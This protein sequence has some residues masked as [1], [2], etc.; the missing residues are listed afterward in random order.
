MD[1]KPTKGFSVS[2][3][4]KHHN[5][6]K[7]MLL[8]CDKMAE[9]Y[10][11]LDLEND[12]FKHEWNS[13]SE[14]YPNMDIVGAIDT[15]PIVVSKGNSKN[16]QPKYKNAVLKA[17]NCCTLT[18]FIFGVLDEKKTVKLWHGS[19][20]DSTILKEQST[21]FRTHDHA[22]R[23]DDGEVR[24]LWLVDGAFGQY[25]GV[26]R[27]YGAPTLLSIRNSQG[28]EPFI[29]ALEF[30]ELL[31]FIRARIEHRFGSGSG[32]CKWN[33][34]RHFTGNA[35]EGG[36][37]D[38]VQAMYTVAM[39]A[40]NVEGYVKHG[41]KGFYPLSL[42]DRKEEILK[43]V[44]EKRAQLQRYKRSKLLKQFLM[45][46]GLLH[47]AER[48]DEE[49]ASNA[50]QQEE[51]ADELML[52]IAVH[53]EQVAAEEGQDPEAHE[54]PERFPEVAFPPDEVADPPDAVAFPVPPQRG[55][56]IGAADFSWEIREWLRAC[57]WPRVELKLEEW[58]L[59][60]GMVKTHLLF[61]KSGT[62]GE[63]TIV[64]TALKAADEVTAQFKKQVLEKE[65]ARF[66]DGIRSKAGVVS[67]LHVTLK[68]RLDSWLQN[69]D[70][71]RLIARE[72][73]H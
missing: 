67:W 29:K 4:H 18:G 38:K 30:N 33:A 11:S 2:N 55:N 61:A 41:W 44:Q 36:S 3:F 64:K 16:M 48:A 50:S 49:E 32:L 40:H 34:V 71:V 10:V 8:I 1:G 21:K 5:L 70:N 39:I 20:A 12:A 17:L 15:V 47:V 52:Q 24:T 42:N 51:A 72:S 73:T 43:H 60:Q 35:P 62:A 26:L 31:G 57:V 22:L 59:R 63:A 45:D 53:Q 9:K 7:L 23:R 54:Q 69:R 6:E 25:P 46:D 13:C 19:E 27:P 68:S 37:L 58:L 65:N 66:Y 14:L 28:K 56:D